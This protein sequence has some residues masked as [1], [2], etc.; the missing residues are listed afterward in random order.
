MRGGGVRSE[1]VG[2]NP[3]HRMDGGEEGGD[4]WNTWGAIHDFR[5]QVKSD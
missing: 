4:D 3:D 1:Y 2:G 5:A